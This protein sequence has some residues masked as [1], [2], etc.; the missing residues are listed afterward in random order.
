LYRVIEE[1]ESIAAGRRVGPRIFY[2]GATFDG[3]R[4]YYTGAL[5]LN[6]SE[7]LEQEL[8]WAVSLGYDLVKTYVRL[9][10]PPE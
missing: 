5:A 7:E 9:P 3:D 10:D 4:I 8:K 6:D 1:R 2:T